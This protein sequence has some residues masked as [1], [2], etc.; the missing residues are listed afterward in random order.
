MRP[1][2]SLIATL[3]L[4]TA[5]APAHADDRP[6]SQQDIARIEAELR[7]QRQLLQ[8]LIQVLQH[9][10]AAEQA[11]LD[12]LQAAVQ[13]GAA[14]PA[15]ERLAPPDAR[16]GASTPGDARRAAAAD[17][18]TTAPTTPSDSGGGVTGS[19][20]MH[21]AKAAWVYVDDIAASTPGT[22]TMTQKARA[23]VPGAL[24]VPVGTKLSFPNGDPIFHNVFS[25]SSVAAFDLGS[26]PQGESRTVTVTR[27]GPIDVF[28]NLHSGMR[29]FVLVVPGPLFVK[30]GTGG[31]FTLAGVP[32]GKHRV[33]A[34]VPGTAP[35]VKEVV[36]AAGRTARLDFDVTV[37]PP[38]AHLRKDGTPYGSYDE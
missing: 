7:A 36:I 18:R 11:S 2:L 5:A 4:A 9:Q 19:V 30:A 33:A 12:M 10:L 17:P 14:P 34:W 25:T 22:A 32:P 31:K 28:C 38:V 8:S 13:N 29:G 35:V 1:T 24:V 27:P 3:A 20:T 23:F 21:G 15:P 37:A 26:Y 6:P 16:P